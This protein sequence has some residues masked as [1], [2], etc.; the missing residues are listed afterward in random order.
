MKNILE[1]SLQ[2]AHS[3]TDYKKMVLELLKEGRSTG[4]N[5]NEDLFHFT[6]F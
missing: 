6:K 1:K 3:Y 5:Q 4:I 2:I